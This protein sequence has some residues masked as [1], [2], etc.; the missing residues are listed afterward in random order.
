MLTDMCHVTVMTHL[1][2]RHNVSILQVI[3]W[4]VVI[5]AHEVYYTQDAVALVLLK[6]LCHL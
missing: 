4:A 1:H 2:H 6:H 3:Q 5:I